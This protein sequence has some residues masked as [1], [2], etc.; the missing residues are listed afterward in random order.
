MAW[1]DTALQ[2]APATINSTVTGNEK[3]LPDD[4]FLFLLDSST[5][6]GLNLG[7]LRG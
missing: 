2:G 4:I 6:L 7:R 5:W 1:G 3:I